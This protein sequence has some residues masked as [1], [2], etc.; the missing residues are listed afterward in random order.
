MNKEDIYQNKAYIK[1]HLFS[2]SE[3]WYEMIALRQITVD[4]QDT[5]ATIART[6]TSEWV[7]SGLESHQQRGRT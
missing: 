7:N 4:S 3:L 1:T 6:A 5:I 2:Y